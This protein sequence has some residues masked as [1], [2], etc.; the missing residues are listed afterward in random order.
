LYA[1]YLAQDRGL[2]QRTIDTYVF[3]VKPFLSDQLNTQSMKLDGLNAA[4]VVDYIRREAARLDSPLSAQRV[5]TSLRSFLRYARYRDAIKVDLAC[6]VPSAASWS[7]SSIPRAIA[8][9][10]ARRVLA[11]CNRRINVGRRDY[12]ILLLLARLGLR[13]SEIVS[14]KLDDIDW[15]SGTLSVCGKQR[16]G[17]AFPLPPEVGAAIA[18]Y[19]K[20]G[21]PRCTNRHVFLCAQA[22]VRGFKN[23]TAVCSVVQYA[24]ARAGIDSPR[25]GTHQFRHA[26]ATTMLRKGSSLSEIGEVLRHRDPDTTKIYTKVDLHSLRKLAPPWPSV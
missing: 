1:S 13:G 7:M 16:R 19:L 15:E 2:S 14:L 3:S 18:D 5:A 25:K 22:P 26:L 20:N 11:S 24:L 9:N 17:S 8:P 4:D 23:H 21:R 10:H 6:V 12:A